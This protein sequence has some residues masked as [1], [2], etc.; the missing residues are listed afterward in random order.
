MENRDEAVFLYINSPGGSADASEILFESI[1]SLS[2]IKP[3]FALLGSVAASGGYYIACA[4]N[5]I[6]AS[7]LS[8][9]GSIGVI[10]IRPDL[11][12]LYQKIGVRK[13]NLF[14]DPT[15]DIYSETGK[16]SAPAKQLVQR[17]LMNN[18]RLFLH[19]VALGRKQKEKDL[20]KMAE[21]RVFTAKQFQEVKMIDGHWNVLEVLDDYKK[22]CGVPVER[23]YHLHCYP[24]LK[25]DLHSLA[26]AYGRHSRME[27]NH[28][29]P[30]GLLPKRLL[31]LFTQQ[32][33]LHTKGEP[34]FY[35]PWVTALHN[36]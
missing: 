15:R 12:G 24:Q 14:K 23:E 26:S 36:L 5:R 20:E 29:L 11:Q 3:V 21:G 33:L 13:E 8:I 22:S 16:L 6:Y 32:A 25:M 35:L 28:L 27:F 19:R 4:A 18:Y 17:T 7:P 31:D 10:R 30:G 1:Y 34:L 2:R 9:T